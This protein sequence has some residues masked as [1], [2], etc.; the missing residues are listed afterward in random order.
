M[1]LI[2]ESL[3][4]VGELLRSELLPLIQGSSDSLLLDLVLFAGT[5]HVVKTRVVLS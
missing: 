5:R 4:E 3:F 2:L 1:S